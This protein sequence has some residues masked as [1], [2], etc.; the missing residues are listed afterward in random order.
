MQLKPEE[1]FLNIAAWTEKY[2]NCHQIW[3]GSFLGFLIINHPEFAKT[4]CSRG[5]KNNNSVLFISLIKIWRV[6][7]RE[8]LKSCALF[9][10]SKC[11]SVWFYW[12]FK[13]K[14]GSVKF[15][16]CVTFW[17]IKMC[18]IQFMC[19]MYLYQYLWWIHLFIKILQAIAY[20]NMMRGETL[21]SPLTFQAS[22]Y[23]L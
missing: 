3:F 17:K 13:F 7:E 23:K 22:I 14:L 19:D 2:P 21:Q 20:I 4:V 9:L 18:N 5:G 6:W 16:N 1:E 11:G 10:S 12:K 15:K 8:S